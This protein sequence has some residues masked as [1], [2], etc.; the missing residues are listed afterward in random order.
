MSSQV[1]LRS[2]EQEDREYIERVLGRND[3]PIADISEKLP[4]LYVC[5]TE[6]DRVGVGGIE[7][8][9]DAALLRSV[10]VEKSERGN[11]YGTIISNKVLAQAELSGVSTVYLLTTTA[12][13]FFAD[14]GFVEIPRETVPQSI[15]T[16]TEFSDL[17]PET[18]VCM[19]RELDKSTT[20]FND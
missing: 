11:G 5:E 9:D 20:A 1:K 18:A 12:D 15:Q 3:L 13:E 4:C 16:T 17:C 19:K 10:A 6:T 8:Y 14:L 7:L 2:A